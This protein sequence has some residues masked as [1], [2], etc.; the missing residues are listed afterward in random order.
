MTDSATPE[1]QKPPRPVPQY[2]C[3]GFGIG[4]GT[5]D[6]TLLLHHNNRPI[7][8]VSLS[9]TV[10]KTIGIKLMEAI[11]RLEQQS[12]HEIMTIE[13]TSKFLNLQSQQTKA[14]NEPETGSN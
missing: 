8:H 7:A 12:G 11:T 1:S 6:V 5:A 10:A 2:Y 3:N 14:E 13:D 9:F 4:L